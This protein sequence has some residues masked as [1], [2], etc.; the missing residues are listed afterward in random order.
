MNKP[1]LTTKTVLAN[2]FVMLCISFS[3]QQRQNY[4]QAWAVS[5]PAEHHWLVE[6]ATVLQ[7]SKS[8]TTHELVLV[9]VHMISLDLEP[10]IFWKL[11]RYAYGLNILY[12]TPEYFMVVIDRKLYCGT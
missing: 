2:N 9:S 10:S 8:P 7:G 3:P 12:N 1:V 11:L 5:M 4:V 6:S